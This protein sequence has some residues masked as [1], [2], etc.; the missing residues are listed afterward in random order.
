MVFGRSEGP[1]PAHC[2]GGLLGAVCFGLVVSL[3]F[4]VINF[5]SFL[6]GVCTTFSSPF[7]EMIRSSPACSRKKK[8]TCPLLSEW[9]GCL[10]LL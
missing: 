2:Q 5:S 8:R 7:N 1:L 9:C 6:G 10:W 4:Q 3:E